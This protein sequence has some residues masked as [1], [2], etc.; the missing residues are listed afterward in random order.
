MKVS[1]IVPLLF[2][3]ACM[4]VPAGSVEAGQGSASQTVATPPAPPPPPCQDEIYHAFDFWLGNWDVYDPAGNL[5]GTNSITSAESGCLLIEHWTN[6]G[7]GTGQSYNFYDPGTGQWRQL[8][9]SAGSIID[10]SGGLTEE[11]VMRLEGEIHAQGTG[12]VAPFTGEWTP[13]DDGSV[14]Q[15]FRQQ[16]TDTG[17]WSDSFVGRYVKQAKE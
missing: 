14:T 6:T 4:A 5:V 1:L 10:Y 9:V 17:E 7:G 13:N 2:T 3:A 15:H 12:A 8:W 11:G 16:S